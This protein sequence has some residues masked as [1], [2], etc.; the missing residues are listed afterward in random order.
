M[1]I[2]PELVT[3]SIVSADTATPSKLVQIMIVVKKLLLFRIITN[4]SLNELSQIGNVI[5]TK[6]TFRLLPIPQ[7]FSKSKYGRDNILSSNSHLQGKIVYYQ[8]RRSKGEML[9]NNS[10]F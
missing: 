6:F 3:L 9:L 4:S 8:N 1:V 5:L 7:R 10:E 2:V